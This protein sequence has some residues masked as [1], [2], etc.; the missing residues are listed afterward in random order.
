MPEPALREREFRNPSEE[1]VGETLR[2]AG[3]D[4][5]YEGRN[6][7]YL[8]PARKAEYL[9][10]F[11]TRIGNIILEVKGWFGKQGAKE[12]QKYILVREA[13]PELDIR[14]VFTDANKKIYKKSPTTYAKWADDHGFKWS[15]KLHV[16][17]Q[18]LEDMKRE[19]KRC[20]RSK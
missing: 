11:R 2:A 19:V 5:E 1:R 15:T 8:V 6:V 7:E 16:P 18:W 9:P 14:F 13:H 20:K 10:D 3:I 4:F 17:Q 12:R